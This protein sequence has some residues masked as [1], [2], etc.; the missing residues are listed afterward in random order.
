MP[1]N[2]TL[3][4]LSTAVSSDDL[5]FQPTDVSQRPYFRIPPLRNPIPSGSRKIP[6]PLEPDT[7]SVRES[8]AAKPLNLP[9]GNP[10]KVLPT[11]EDFLKAARKDTDLP[12]SFGVPPSTERLPKNSLPAF[13]SLRAVENLSHP[14]FP[15]D[16]PRKRR[17]LDVAGESSLTDVVQ[18]PIPKVQKEV[19]K[20]RPFSPLPVL[21]ELK[22]P[23]PNAALFPPIL[24]SD[25]RHEEKDTSLSAE[26]LISEQAGERRT[27]RIEDIIDLNE[28]AGVASENQ[29][30]DPQKL[31]RASA[32]R[33]GQVAGPTDTS[34]RQGKSIKPKKKLRKWTEQETHDLLSGVVRCGV[35]H[36]T[37]I[38]SQP[39]LKFNNRTAMNLKDRFRVCCPWAYEP[40]HGSTSDDTRARLADN[41]SDAQSGLVAKILLPDPRSTKNAPEFNRGPTGPSGLSQSVAQSNATCGTKVSNSY[42]KSQ[43][44]SQKRS[45][46]ISGSKELSNKSK[47]TLI[48]LG[49]HDPDMAVK[50]SR[51]HRRPF[52]AAED[53]SLLKGYAVHGFQW[54]LIRQDKHL[55]L[56]HR[57]ATD[58]RD[59]FR[60]KF[61]NVYRE[62][63]FT[64]TK[65]KDAIL[66]G[67]STFSP[68][69]GIRC[70]SG[71]VS[72]S[73]FNGDTQN[74]DLAAVPIDPAMSP[75]AP[76]SSL[77]EPPNV[78]VTPLF[79]LLLDDGPNGAEESNN[80]LRWSENTLPPLV[81]DELS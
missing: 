52:T 10:P 76:P 43:K 18:L 58:L 71:A 54:T 12:H 1:W 13:I 69:D 21:N 75:P 37:A 35:G 38:L 62:G 27:Q 17:R 46:G 51:R 78:P 24:E 72:D 4:S 81:W 6:S 5:C 25:G 67:R 7:S 23:P 22:E 40:G 31:H 42:K 80:P 70:R 28:E 14:S 56:L 41:I 47:S 33:A 36:W 63:G 39:D 65:S 74:K 9:S 45:S 26:L 29:E 59:R 11:L 61:P 79:S 15:D 20:Q 57:K 48:S 2:E 77:P 60:T 49:L 34:S 64:T 68:G 55:N 53:D 32:D 3:D 16:T 73:K 8:S 66:N 19:L 44:Q 30:P 50:S